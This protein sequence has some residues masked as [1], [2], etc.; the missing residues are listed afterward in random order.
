MSILEGMSSEEK[1]RF[2]AEHN[3]THLIR[4]VSSADVTALEDLLLVMAKN[5]EAAMTEAGA[6]PGKDYTYRDLFTMALP[7]A[8]EMWKAN[9]EKMTFSTNDF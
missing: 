8:L 4:Y 1:Q 7:F 9:R 3:K 5:V 6:E 2:L